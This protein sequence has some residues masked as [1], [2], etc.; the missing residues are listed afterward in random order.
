M[1][2]NV[3][4]FA[5]LKVDSEDMACAIA[6]KSNPPLTGCFDH[7]DRHPR[8]E[9]FERPFEWFENNI[10]RRILPKQNVVLEVDGVSRD[11]GDE[12]RYELALYMISEPG[13]RFVLNV[14]WLEN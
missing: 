2:A 10:E 7:E 5:A 12:H 6:A 4:A 9:P 14:G 8:D 13:E 11:L 1:L 3:E